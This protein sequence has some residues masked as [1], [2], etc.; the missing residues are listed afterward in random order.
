MVSPSDVLVALK[1][2]LVTHPTEKSIKC[3]YKEPERVPF[4]LVCDCLCVGFRQQQPGLGQ[5]NNHHTLVK[6]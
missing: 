5:W 3:I 4:T 6:A 2:K 1:K